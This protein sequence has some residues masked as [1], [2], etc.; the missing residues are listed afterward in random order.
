MITA[1]PDL[2][3]FCGAFFGYAEDIKRHLESRGRRVAL[4]DDRPA[5]DSVTK[6]LIRL[7]PY[8]ISHQTEQYFDRIITE[9]RGYPICDILVV[10]A[11]GFSPG[12]VHRL[13][14]AFPPPALRSI[15]GIVS[16]ICR[17]IAGKK[18]RCSTE[19]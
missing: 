5:T 4:F 19:F 13:R 12:T 3:L 7:A 10:K 11:E 8:L 15:F 16:A 17:P 6:S 2:L 14:S 18:P 9:M 1:G